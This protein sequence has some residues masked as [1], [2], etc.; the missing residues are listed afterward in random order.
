MFVIWIAKGE[1]R[2]MNSVYFLV[3]S[4][5]LRIV[6]RNCTELGRFTVDRCCCGPSLL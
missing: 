2:S 6:D 3:F 1:G 4:H 5:Y